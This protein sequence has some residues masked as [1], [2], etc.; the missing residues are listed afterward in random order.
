MVERKLYTSKLLRTSDLSE[1]T[2]H[3]EFTVAEMDRFDFVAGQFISMVAPNS[4]GKMITRAYSVASGPRGNPLFDLCLNR[5]EGGFFSNFLC[6]LEDGAEVKFHGPHGLFVLRKPLRDCIFI[7]TGTGIAPMRSFVEWLFWDKANPRHE[8]RE[9]YLVYGTRYVE[10]MYYQEEFERT[11]AEFPNFHYTMT[12]S[13]PPEN[14]KGEKGYVQDKV[15]NLLL[16]RP[17]DQR[18]NLDAYICG[19]NDMVSANRDM[20]KNEFGWDKKQ[21]IFE[22][23][24]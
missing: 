24:D 16:Q 11:A 6:D 20:L 2:K 14:W 4:E 19:L 17:E 9:I 23:Y 21:I 3:F 13:R 12:L 22:R 5:V 1:R 7:A 10:D 18:A 8:G 15:R